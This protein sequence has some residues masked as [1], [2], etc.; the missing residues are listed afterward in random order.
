MLNWNQV[1]IEQIVIWIKKPPK[2]WNKRLFNTLQEVASIQCTA[3]NCIFFD[4]NL[5][6][7]VYVDDLAVFGIN[8]LQNSKMK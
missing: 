4:W 8:I 1:K 2:T 7:A 5:L 3:D 6:L